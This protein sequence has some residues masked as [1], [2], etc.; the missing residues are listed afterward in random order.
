M[1]NKPLNEQEIL[2]D[3]LT[4]EKQMLN[5]YST[6][7]AEATCQNLRE[8]LNRIITETQ[9]TQFEIYNAM[10]AKGWYQGKNAQL[11][12]VQQAQQKFNTVKMSL[13]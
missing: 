6:F 10:Q 12:E 2:N 7:I 13:E 9:Q 8:Q 1:T 3:A 11:N 4:T 5:A